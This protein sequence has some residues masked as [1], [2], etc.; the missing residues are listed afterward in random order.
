MLEFLKSDIGKVA[1]GGAIAV[2]GQLTATLIGWLKEA[3]LA[4]TKKRKDAEYLAMRLV[5]VLDTLVGACYNAVHDPLTEDNQGILENTVLDPTLTLPLDG[6]YKALPR[7]LMYELLSMPNKLDGINEG[8]SATA[9]ISGPPDHQEYYEYREEHWS[10]LGLKALGL[11]DA[12]C[13]QYKIP[14]PER[15]PHYTPRESF[16]EVVA[17][18]QEAKR[19]RNERNNATIAK[20][21]AAATLPT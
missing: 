18:I 10:K 14:P 7:S 19:E 13:H 3:R 6:D 20:L 12:L 11:I 2:A 8:L 4:A 5:L 9:N 1:L 21:S 16:R 17:K 15:P